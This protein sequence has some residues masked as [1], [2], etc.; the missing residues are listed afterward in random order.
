MW[1]RLSVLGM[2]RCVPGVLPLAPGP[3]EE[4]L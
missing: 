2:R 3:S 1:E 4:G